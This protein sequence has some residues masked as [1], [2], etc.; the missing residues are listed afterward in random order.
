MYVKVVWRH[1]LID[2]PVV[3]YSEIDAN[4]YEVRKVEVYRDGNMDWADGD[5]STGVTRLSE[6]RFP[7]IAEIGRQQQFVPEQIS[8]EEFEEVWRAAVR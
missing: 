4:G 1:Q 7:S 5:G 6:T 8:H 2:E 3:L